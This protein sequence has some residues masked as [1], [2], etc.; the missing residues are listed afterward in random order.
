MPEVPMPR[1][2]DTMTEGT[3]SQWLKNEGDAVERGEVIAEV[4]TDKA[5]MEVEAFDAGVLTR[6]LVAAGESATIGQ[7]IA[8]IDGPDGAP[9]DAVSA[10][11]ATAPAPAPT[12]L[13]T[14]PATPAAPAEL[15]VETDAATARVPISPL[16]A[17]I[18]REHGI[19]VSAIAGSGPRGRI[20]RA[21]VEAAIAAGRA[22]PQS[23]GPTVPLAAD[24]TV[25]DEKIPLTRIRRITARRLTESAAAPH[26]DLTATADVAALM[27]LRD[28]F[29]SELAGA[30]STLSVT[31]LLIRACAVTLRSH[32]QLNSSWGGDHLIRHHRIHIGVAV[33]VEDGLIVPVIR[34]A[35][36]KSITEI[37]TEAHMLTDR[38]RGG[39]LTLDEITGGTFTIT[40]LGMYGIDH[41][42][43]VINPPEAAV[44]AVGAAD[45]RPVVRDGQLTTTTVLTLTLSIDHRVLDGATGAVFLRD[46]THLLEHPLRILI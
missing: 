39:H 7:P 45:E 17:A 24:A 16:A 22:Q 28:E 1:L 37:A 6:I 18:A 30:G 2:S 3:L 33:A 44:L 11:P 40:N 8:I 27:R 20:V 38:G 32:P 13:A 23:A 4:E 5:T 34:D 9:S 35:D 41:F 15:L 14:A 26:F 25:D 19:D 31:D 12:G 46:L 42:T 10:A 29:N 43:A 36:R 21:D